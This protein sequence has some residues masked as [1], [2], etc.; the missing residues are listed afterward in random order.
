[1]P[2]SVVAYLQGRLGELPPELRHNARLWT[3]QQA[4]TR[5]LWFAPEARQKIQQGL[6]RAVRRGMP[7]L[8]LL[9]PRGSG[10][11]S[12]LAQLMSQTDQGVLEVD[13]DSMVRQGVSMESAARAICREA[14]LRRALLLLRMDELLD[15]AEAADE[16]LRALGPVLS[17]YEGPVAL[18]ARRSDGAVRRALGDVLEITIPSPQAEDRVGLWTQAAQARQQELP[19][20]LARSMARRF[21]LTPGAIEQAIQEV[22]A[23]GLLGQRGARAGQLDAALDS[24]VRRQLEH[25]LHSLAEPFSTSLGW[26]DVILDEDTREV[27]DE[28]RSHAKHRDKVYDRWG[29][30]R[31]MSYGRGLSCLFT[32]PPGTGKTTMAAVLGAELGREVYRIDLARVS[33]KWVGETE[34][35]LSRVFEEAEKAQVILLFDEADS[36]FSSRTRVSSANDRFANMEI[37]YLLQRMESYDGVTVLTTNF[38]QGIDEAFKRR[39]KFRVHFPLPDADHRARMWETMLPSEAEREEEIDFEALGEDFELSGGN[40][41]NAVLRAAFYAAAQERPIHFEHL[42]LAAQAEAREMGQLIRGL[43]LDA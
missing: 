31:K 35:N 19:R 26:E 22:H 30:R 33:S 13:M 5:D 39:I 41:R 27:L 17:G 28:I 37:N 24:S 23:E 16:A 12:L 7:R 2:D 6:R 10:R 8:A 43:D 34:K 11:R 20:G 38:E 21:S 36:L 32:G 1:V 4:P 18:T 29:F 9:A 14:R 3:P 42:E 15:R 25:S 40:I